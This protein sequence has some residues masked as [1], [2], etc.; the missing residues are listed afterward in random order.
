MPAESRGDP[1]AVGSL[2]G[3]IVRAACQTTSLRV[4]FSISSEALLSQ[5]KLV[6]YHSACA[7][8]ALQKGPPE[9]AYELAKGCSAPFYPRHPTHR[10]YSDHG[11][12]TRLALG[13][14][15]TTIDSSLLAPLAPRQSTNRTK[16][17]WW[18]GSTVAVGGL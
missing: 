11:C 10:R 9:A 14:W 8:P 3:W 1:T 4:T 5:P 12:P 17:Q 2:C 13:S 16:C 7:G 6:N 18:N 15:R